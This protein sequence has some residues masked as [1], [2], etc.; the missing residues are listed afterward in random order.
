MDNKDLIIFLL[1]VLIILCIFYPRFDKQEKFSNWVQVNPPNQI[2]V[3]E[4]D[5]VVQEDIISENVV[6][7]YRITAGQGNCTNCNPK[8][9][10]K[11][12]KPVCNKICKPKCEQP[13]CFINCSDPGPAACSVECQPPQCEVICPKVVGLFFNT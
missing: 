8:C 5:N 9:S 11:C 6:A 1:F 10:W 3:I 4:T 7:D 12:D 13:S 2:D